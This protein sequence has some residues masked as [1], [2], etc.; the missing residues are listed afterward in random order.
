MWK[1][2][3]GKRGY[4]IGCVRSV[5]ACVKTAARNPIPSPWMDCGGRERETAAVKTRRRDP[6]PVVANLARVRTLGPQPL[7][8]NRNTQRPKGK[9]HDG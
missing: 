2:E 4:G 8:D 6:R 3:E 1:G 7:R 9:R 5:K